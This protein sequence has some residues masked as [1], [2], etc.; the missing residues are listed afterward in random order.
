MKLKKFISVFKYSLEEWH[1]REE[2]DYSTFY[3]RG[4]GSKGIP[5]DLLD[6]KIAYVNSGGKIEVVLKRGE[7]I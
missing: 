2:G 3:Y 6:K 4:W 1:I 7:I 5:E